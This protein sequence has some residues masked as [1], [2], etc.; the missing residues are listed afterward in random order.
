M[1]LFGELPWRCLSAEDVGGGGAVVYVVIAKKGWAGRQG[2]CGG[3]IVNERY[4][5]T[6][7]HCLENF[8]IR[9][10]FKVYMGILD[11][12]QLSESKEVRTV[13]DVILPEM[14]ADGTYRHDADI[15]VLKLDK[16]YSMVRRRPTYPHFC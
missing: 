9:P 4:I 15:A 1:A 14:N 5:L 11:C 16:A 2:S 10:D 6:A 7:A 12:Y 3:T 8:E 13:V